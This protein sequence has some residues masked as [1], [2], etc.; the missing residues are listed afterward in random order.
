[1][2]L[3]T[4]AP[5]PTYLDRFRAA[6][7]GDESLAW[8]FWSYY[9]LIGF[10]LA[11]IQVAL[12]PLLI[13][14]AGGMSAFP[15]TAIGQMFLLTSDLVRLAY[16]CSAFILIV[17]CLANVECKGWQ[18]AAMVLLIGISKQVLEQ[19]GDVGAAVF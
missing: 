13:S 16:F 6:W 7:R 8:V 5:S 1:M 9:V 2:V 3:T 10:A 15:E 14:I 12:L 19:A 17:R 4:Y 18:Y 11:A